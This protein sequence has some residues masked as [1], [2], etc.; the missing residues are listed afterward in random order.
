VKYETS[1]WVRVGICS[2]LH[3]L[4]T[5]ATSTAGADR[6]QI[7]GVLLLVGVCVTAHQYCD[8]PR[9]ARYEGT[10]FL[11]D[12]YGARPLPGF[13]P[14]ALGFFSSLSFTTCAPISPIYED[15]LFGGRLRTFRRKLLFSGVEIV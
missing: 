9:N 7:C 1:L 14:P 6:S 3:F 12:L 15:D 2:P 10:V 11:G 13:A 4:F 5:A 8:F